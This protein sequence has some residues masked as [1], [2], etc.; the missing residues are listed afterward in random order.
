MRARWLVAVFAV[1]LTAC[2]SLGADRDH[3]PGLWGD[4]AMLVLGSGGGVVSVDPADGSV[5]FR[6]AGVSTLGSWSTVFTTRRSEGGTVLEGR[7]AATGRVRSTI[8]LP[9]ELA[10]RVASLDGSQVALMEPLPEGHSPWTPVPRATTD[11]VVADPTGV[12]DPMR[13]HLPGNLEPEAF[14]VDG[15]TL[16]MIRFVPP[17]EPTAYRVSGLD[18]SSGRVSPVATGTKP[19]IVE[20][21]SGTRLEQ[22]ASPD[23][24]MLYT[25]YT[26]DPASYAGPHAHQAA[27]VAFIHTLDLKEGWAHCIALPEAMWGGDPRNEAMALSPDG[28]RLHVVDVARD[29]VAV[30]DTHSLDMADFEFD[31]SEVG[32]PVHASVGPAGEL[33]VSDGPWLTAVNV[34]RRTTTGRRGMPERVSALG[35]G[36]GGLYV[37]L[38]HGVEVLSPD[39]RRRVATIPSPAVDDLDYVGVVT[40]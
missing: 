9:G 37:A 3:A 18:L 4:D 7:D 25:L 13:F 10:V 23:G 38:T 12:R 36:P 31:F 17:T 11:I 39:L 33:F 24:R 22:L 30:M 16:Y 20:T 14:S 34:W 19:R 27:P 29:L 32:G 28:D 35:T 6:G 2:G 21:M 5:R 8:S 26:T 40:P 1:S 15:R